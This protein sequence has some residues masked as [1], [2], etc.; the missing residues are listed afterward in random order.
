[1]A[2]EGSE[3]A[4]IMNGGLTVKERL[5]RIEEG[6]GRIEA[7]VSIKADRSDVIA[8]T[9][10][11]TAL[12]TRL[13]VYDEKTVRQIADVIDARKAVVELKDGQVSMTK[14]L[15]WATATVIGVLTASDF[16]IRFLSQVHH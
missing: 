6:I 4:E 15:K 16:V 9:N 13:A 14:A 8:L 7:A 5:G 1:M 2:A 10:R 11:V 12:E 3:S